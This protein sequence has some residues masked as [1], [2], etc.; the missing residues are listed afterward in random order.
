MSVGEQPRIETRSSSTSR[1]SRSAR[2]VRRAL[3]VDD[4]GAHRA[5]ADHRPRPHDPAHVGGEVDDVARTRVGLVADLARD[6]DEKAALDV[7]HALRPPG[8]AGR[9]REQVRVLRVD[10]ERLELARAVGEQLVERREHDVL[11]RRRVSPRFL[12]RREHRNLTAAAQRALDG[13]RDLR[14]GVGEPLGDGGRREAGEDRHLHGAD[15]RAGV[16]RDG[17]L[18]RHGQVDDDAVAGLDAEPH[19]RLGE[20]RH[21]RREL[22]ERQLAPRAV[23]AAEHRCRRRRAARRPSGGRSSTRC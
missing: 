16:R 13:D 6:R 12:E 19:E 1:Q 7:Q 18:R 8:R 20:P 3:R 11:E 10:G 21:L 2:P 15:V 4:R 9:V 22:G 23:L 14:L 5:A 17:D